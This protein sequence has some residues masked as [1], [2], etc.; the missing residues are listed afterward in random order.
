MKAGIYN[1]PSGSIGGAEY[2]V[3]ALGDALAGSH[4]VEIVHHNPS[5]AIE[6][7]RETSGLKLPGVRLRYVVREQRPDPSSPSGLQHLPRRCVAERRWHAT[8][9]RPYDVFINTTH[10]IPPFCHARTGVLLTLFPMQDRHTMWPWCDDADASSLTVKRRVRRACFEAL[11]RSRFNSYRHKLSISR[12]TQ[13]WVKKWWNVDTSVLYPPVDTSFE[14]RPK[15][16][17]V[18][19]VGRFTRWIPSKRQ[20][21]MMTMYEELKRGPL[22][23]WSYASVGGLSDDAADREYFEA[24]ARLA[25]ACGGQV[26]PNVTRPQLRALYEE[27]GIFWHAAGYGGTQQNNP[28]EA[29]HFGIAPVEAMA[30]GAVPIVFDK[31][32]LTEIVEHGRSGFLWRTLDELRQYTTQVAS[33]DNLRERMSEAARLRAARF[34]RET[35]CRS[36][37]ALLS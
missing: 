16:P 4:E 15:S 3:A 2:V 20:V 11:W 33:D 8:L 24:V 21:E 13:A 7:L 35:F 14:R 28:Y 34:A 30:A 31:G 10:G 22:R 29:E 27:S 5:L 17:A 12:Y 37:S 18:L 1:E 32:G 23:D 36:I 6:Q 25:L 19:S 9:S 26:I